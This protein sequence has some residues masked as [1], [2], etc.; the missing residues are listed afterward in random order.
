VKER[1][2]GV[3]LENV[4]KLCF[5]AAMRSIFAVGL[6]LL[7]AFS[8]YSQRPQSWGSVP[9]E[10]ENATRAFPPQLRGD[11]AKLRDAALADDYAY[12]QLEYLTD[13]IGPRPQGSPQADAAARYVADEMR[14]LG[15]D[16]HLEPVP[17]RH[18][19][20]GID[21][22]ELVEYPG[23]V[24]G[25]RQKI[26]VTALLGNSPTTDAGITADVV[27]VND[28]DELKAL[29]RDKV[30]GKIVL[31]NYV[32]DHRKAL[33]GRS[34]PAYGEAVLYR[35]SGAKA[36]YEMGAVGSL[37]RSAGDGAFRLAHTGWSADAPIPS[38]AV[39]AEDAGLIARLA[40]RGK[41]R[42][43][44]TLTTQQ[45]PEGQGYNVVADLKGSE[46]PEQIVIVSGHLDSWDLGTGAIDD[47]A[48][49]VVAM[50]TAE[51]VHRLGLHPKR[52]IRVIAWMNEEAGAT[53]R[54]AYA[55]DH[56]AEIPNH[57]AAMESD[58]GAE[59]PLGFRVKISKAGEQELS[60][61]QEV[62]RPIGANLLDQVPDSPDTD[63]EPLVDKGV[64]GFGVWQNGLT[65]FTYHHTAA[66]TLDKVVPQ[67]LR[68][69]A[70]CMAVM[71]YALADMTE[72]LAK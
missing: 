45:G 24:E 46:H 48:G 63:I 1:A 33:A 50:E 29:G 42:L 28:F 41:V 71:G 61:V 11:L 14:K 7:I 37:V 17:V 54:D 20:R 15:L 25:T 57:V 32:Y 43:H 55:K 51:L 56:A 16:V 53:G 4:Q 26:V 13:S 58:G 44:L 68:E 27:V 8:A 22:A 64:P 35:G 12:K 70:A 5:E 52:T 34:G 3:T 40:A 38:G 49:V 31:Y 9:P 59:H 18:F 39:S 30:A 66:D 23:Q 19:M 2:L 21:T 60:P 65:Y 62:L 36:A 69:N 10:S 6:S 72:P 47:G 67:E